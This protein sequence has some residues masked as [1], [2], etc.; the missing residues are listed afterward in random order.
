MKYEGWR[1][2]A[3]RGIKDKGSTFFQSPDPIGNLIPFP[4]FPPAS[5]TLQPPSFRYRKDYK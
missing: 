3:G 5:F 1:M 4:L 2:K